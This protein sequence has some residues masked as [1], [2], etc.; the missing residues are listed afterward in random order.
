[1]NTE[2]PARARPRHVAVHNARELA[3]DGKPR[4]CRRDRRAVEES[5]WG[6]LLTFEN[7]VNV[8]RATR[9]NTSDT[10]IP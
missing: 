7:T 1:M 3:G 6:E 8:L 5:G 4:G 2:P 9:R 10:S